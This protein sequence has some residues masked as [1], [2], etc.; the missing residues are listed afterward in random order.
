MGILRSCVVSCEEALLVFRKWKSEET[1]LLFRAKS[2]THKFALLGTLESAESEGVR[3]RIQDFGYIEMHV[4]A[5]V[6]FEYFDPATVRDTPS[7]VREKLAM[8]EPVATGAGILA[9]NPASESF[10]FLE[11]LLA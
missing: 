3:F 5:D 11:I 2:S 4:S 7:D 6:T 1:L 8:L 10:M 9:T